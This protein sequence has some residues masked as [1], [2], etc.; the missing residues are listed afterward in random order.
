MNTASTQLLWVKTLVVVQPSGFG[1]GGRHLSGTASKRAAA[2][3]PEVDSGC[4]S[5][6]TELREGSSQLLSPE[7]VV[8]RHS[9]GA[10]NV[11]KVC[12]WQ[13][14]SETLCS[15]TGGGIPRGLTASHARRVPGTCQTPKFGVLY[16]LLGG[17]NNAQFSTVPADLLRRGRAS[18]SEPC[19]MS[20][21]PSRLIG[22][23]NTNQKKESLLL[24]KAE[25]R[26]EE[27]QA[28]QPLI[29]PFPGGSDTGIWRASGTCA[30]AWYIRGK[31]LLIQVSQ[32]PRVAP[33]RSAEFSECQRSVSNK[34]CYSRARAVA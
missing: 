33:R 25:R 19:R 30:C 31:L 8:Q 10:T 17:K 34:V 4:T 13:M 20:P 18:A 6:L 12:N 22:W 7:P 28:T 15:K 14:K 29:G 21:A 11:S 24:D 26:G 9:E 32:Q 2:F 16:L 3:R 1:S 5:L 27:S 23:Q